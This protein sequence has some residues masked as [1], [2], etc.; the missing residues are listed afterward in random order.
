MRVDHDVVPDMRGQRAAGH[1]A[2][3]R[4]VVIADPDATDIMRG[5]ADEPGVAR[6]LAGPRFAA[7]DLV[8]Q[9]R[10]PSG[11]ADHGRVH[12]VVHFRDIGLIDDAGKPSSL[13]LVEQLAVAVAHAGDDMRGDP[14]AAIGERH[15]GG[16]ELKRRYLG[17]AE[18]KRRAVVQLRAD[19]EPPRRADHVAAADL[20]GKLHRDG[21]DRLGEAIAERDRAAIGAGVVLGRPAVDGDR[22]VIG[23]R[24]RACS[25]FRAR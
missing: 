18:R 22:L 20:V 1:V 12:H 4:A 2:H 23:D 24:V 8:W 6:V 9:R 3:L 10:L 25:R 19:A 21:V 16:D 17:G 15:V 11:A 5:V 7:R 13:V 14:F